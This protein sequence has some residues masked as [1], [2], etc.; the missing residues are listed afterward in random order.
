MPLILSMLILLK[1]FYFVKTCVEDIFSYS[2]EL[3]HHCEKFLEVEFNLYEY[4]FSFF[5]MLLSCLK[6]T[7]Y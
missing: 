1:I 4:I 5:Y 6:E 3:N 7:I 2:S